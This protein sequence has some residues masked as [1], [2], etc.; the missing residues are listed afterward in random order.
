MSIPRRAINRLHSPQLT[1]NVTEADIAKAIKR[2]SNHC[3]IADAIKHTVPGV[4]N[5]S[6]D[7]QTIRWSDPQTHL[8]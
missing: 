3:M 6:V 4:R 2:D 5:V 7:L 1:I 8:R